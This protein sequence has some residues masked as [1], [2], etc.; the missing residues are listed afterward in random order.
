M[1]YHQVQSYADLLSAALFQSPQQLACERV[2][3]CDH[4]NHV[5]VCVNVNARDRAHSRAYDFLSDCALFQSSNAHAR[6][7]Y[8]NAHCHVNAH[9][10]VNAN[11]E[12]Q[13]CR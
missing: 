2:F 12:M 9:V 1:T 13:R 8:A 4:N 7:M 5:H 11:V 6:V 10:H 3:L